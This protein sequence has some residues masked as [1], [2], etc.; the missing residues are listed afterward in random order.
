[1][2]RI[3]IILCILTF[4]LGVFANQDDELVQ[5]YQSDFGDQFYY[6]SQ[7]ANEVLAAQNSGD[8]GYIN[9][10]T[11]DFFYGRCHLESSTQ[12][13]SDNENNSFFALVFTPKVVPIRPIRMEA[14]V[15]WGFGAELKT[16]K[17]NDRRL[18]SKDF[19][20]R[21][22]GGVPVHEVELIVDEQKDLFAITY[23]LNE[24][25]EIGERGVCCRTSNFA[26][27]GFLF[28]LDIGLAMDDW[29]GPSKEIR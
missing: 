16:S 11:D 12:L 17:F 13:N 8:G 29:P 27:L 19:A 28:E 3:S 10:I 2:K 21:L 26:C 6:V 20:I 1:M 9:N 14:P 15:F 22:E 7:S 24:S 18:S 4:S 5:V 25:R 23:Y